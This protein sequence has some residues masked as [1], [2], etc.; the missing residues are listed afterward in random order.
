ML[1]ELDLAPKYVWD[2]SEESLPNG[3]YAVNVAW[4][5]MDAAW[6]DLGADRVA[7]IFWEESLPVLVD[8]YSPK[9]QVDLTNLRW[10]GDDRT[11][12]VFTRRV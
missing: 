4:T 3:T 12:I 9:L 8:C 5:P 10:R 11:E 2:L 6:A 1:R 7:R